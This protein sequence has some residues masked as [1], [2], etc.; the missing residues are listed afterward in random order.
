MKLLI[1]GAQGQLGSQLMDVL[2]SGETDLGA[3]SPIYNEAEIKAVDISGLDI[4]DIA[5]VNNLVLPFKPDIIINCSA[6]TDV[7]GCEVNKEQAMKVNALGPRN[8]AIAAEQ[9]NAKLIHI[10]TDYVFSG[11]GNI[12]FCEYD[13]PSPVSIYGK[14]KLLGEEY[15]KSF[16]SRYFIIRTS[17]LYGYYGRNFV[18]T[19]IKAAK[20]RGKLEVVDD[21]RGNPTFAEDLI[22][23]L[24]ALAI[25]DEYG[26]YHCTGNGECSWYDFA[27]RIVEYADITCDVKPIDTQASNR[28]AKRPAYSALDKMMLRCTI[29]DK[30]RPWED[31]LR[32]FIQKFEGV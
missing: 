12:P 15:I 9:V 28:A 30:M 19:I 4:T 14:S 2:K 17:W 23:H 22:F 3:I 32:S 25:T 1:T 21:Q 11:T 29:G 20:E 16:C 6:Y 26:V 24:L 13:M 10:S 18:K 8:L 27:C 5:A 7:D 31:A